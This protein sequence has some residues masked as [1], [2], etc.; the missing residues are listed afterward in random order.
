MVAKS[1][2]GTGRRT[3]APYA[4]L[5]PA[6]ILFTLTFV[7]PI[8]YAVYLSLR[9]VQVSGL[10]LGKGARREV[11]AGLENYRNA[12]TDPQLWSGTVRVLAY[13]AVLL[14]V[15][16]GLA[17]LFALL[18]DSRRSG[19]R[20]FS[21]ISIFL[22]YA[23]PAVLGSMLWGFLYLPAMSPLN[24]VLAQ[25]GL[26]EPDLLATGTV[27]FSVVNIA[28]WGGVGFNMIVMY[29]SLRAIPRELYE[30]ARI[31]GCSE[32][33]VALRIKIPLL[34]PAIIMTSIFSMIATLQVFSEPLTLRALTNSITSTWTPLMKV[35]TDAFAVD[36]P[37]SAAA[38][39][40]LIAAVTLVVSLGFL[41]LVQR[42]AFG[43][44][45]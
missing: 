19:L 16:L 35:Y 11:F 37:Y 45:H 41:R 5:A 25:L 2:R 29:T 28:V 43:E 3:G 12:L 44:E 1:R 31:D 15:M 22:P 38:T 40:V 24:Y 13:G 30:S 33:Q 27:F 34:L 17:L 6:I 9:K 20:R 10:G 26:P 39:S 18:L 32:L 14:P 42:R 36:D 4:F 23:V 8:A 7:L 21:R